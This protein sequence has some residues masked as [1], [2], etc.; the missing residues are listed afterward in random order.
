MKTGLY[1]GRFQPFHRGHL[2][3]VKQAFAQADFLVIGIGS[4]QESSTEE[5]PWTAKARREMIHQALDAAAIPR[6][7]YRIVEIPDINDNPRWPAHARRIAG[8]CDGVFTGSEIVKELF[9]IYSDFPVFWLKKN[10][11]VN[12][13]TVRQKIISG[14]ALANDLTP[15]IIAW[16]AAHPIAPAPSTD[17]P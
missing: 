13:T 3:A 14:K 10:L 2:D 5:N 8:D 17:K 9:E 15:E 16:I 1:I 7:Q 11:P 4:S 6:E 12:A